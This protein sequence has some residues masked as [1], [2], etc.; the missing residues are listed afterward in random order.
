MKTLGQINL[1]KNPFNETTPSREKQYFW[2]GN[3][4]VKDKISSCYSDGMESDVKQ[5]I[6]NW[7]P[8]GGGKTFSAYFFLNQ[9]KDE[10]IT[11]IY[12]RS[13]K[14]GSKATREIF[15]SIIDELT[16]SGISERIQF[17]I[18]N[19]GVTE[20]TK[21][22]SLRAGIEYTKAILLIGSQEDNV[23]PI[24]NRFLYTSVT[25]SEMKT[26]GLAKPIKTD[27]DLIKFLTGLLSC[28]AFKS[29][30]MDYKLIIWFD[31]M[32]DMIY[33]STKHYKA[34][35]QFLRDLYDN[36]TDNLLIFLNFTLAE[37]EDST[38]ELILGT[39]LWTR[40]LKKIRFKDFDH[41]DAL[42]YASDLLNDAKIDSELS[43]PISTENLKRLLDM[44]TLGN[45]TPR[46]INKKMSA[47]VRF[48]QNNN[49]DEVDE[50]IINSF[51]REQEEDEL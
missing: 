1:E 29:D 22:L 30:Q 41:D 10:N 6:L 42:K 46:E 33:Y 45:L 37:G 28:F 4:I 15:N 13:P 27:N 39:A 32:E 20:L 47:L 49:H 26:L 2:A 19:I 35:S 43:K 18:Q 8:Y 38:I 44:L 25:A 5:L 31:E 23:M 3:E 50:D 34:F 11:Q 51:V 14:D 21:Y 24:M 40:I 17:L 12:V 16:F 9:Y 7:G 36:I 48:A